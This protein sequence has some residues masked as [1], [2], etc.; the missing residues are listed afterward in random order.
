MSQLKILHDAA[1]THGAAKLKKKKIK[2]RKGHRQEVKRQPTELEK[3]VANHF[4]LYTR[5]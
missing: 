5:I 4:S 1:K 3:I 2:T